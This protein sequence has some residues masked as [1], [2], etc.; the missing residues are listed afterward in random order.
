[1]GPTPALILASPCLPTASVL[2]HETPKTFTAR[3]LLGS[4]A[5]A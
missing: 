3:G 4:E 5:C 2:L 1:M